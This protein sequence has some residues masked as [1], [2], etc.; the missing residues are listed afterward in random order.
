MG[1]V[2]NLRRLF[3]ICKMVWQSIKPII[4]R[5][6]SKIALWVVGKDKQ[7][8]LLHHVIFIIG[9]HLGRL[10]SKGREALPANI[11]LGWKWL[12]VTKNVSLQLYGSDYG[13]K[14]VLWVRLDFGNVELDRFQITKK[15]SRTNFTN[16][17]Q[18]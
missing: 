9:P 8:R 10:H 5:F 3:L 7:S 13:R 12:P 18:L 17:L 1:E 14:K 2:F 6:F 11:R 16:H 15:S 4:V